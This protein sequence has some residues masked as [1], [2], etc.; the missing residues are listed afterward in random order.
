MIRR[1]WMKERGWTAWYSWKLSREFRVW[2]EA[3]LVI[4]DLCEPW[5][6]ITVGSTTCCKRLKTSACI[7]FS[8]CQCVIRA[9]CS[10][11]SSHSR[12][13]SSSTGTSSFT[14]SAR[15]CVI[16]LSDI[17]RKK[18]CTRT[19]SWLTCLISPENYP[20]GRMKRRPKK[21]LNTTHSKKMQ[22]LGISFLRCVLTR[23][24][25]AR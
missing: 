6:E 22:P 25:I 24:V 13:A 5:K 7:S 15:V 12:K 11:R 8:S 2:S 20:T 1:R 10:A 21:P 3:C 9:F 14:C 16:G 17:S 19:Q 23:R 4:W 18:P